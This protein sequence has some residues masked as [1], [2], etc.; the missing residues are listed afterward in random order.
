MSNFI[1]ECENTISEVQRLLSLEENKDWKIRYANY[2]TEIAG[3]ID[4]IKKSK[5]KKFHEWAPL[6]L[7][8]NVSAAKSHLKFSLR[9]LGQDVAKLKVNS[10]KIIISTKD[11]EKKNKRDFKCDVPLRDCE[12]RSIDARKFRNHFSSCLKRTS[13]SRKNNDE[14][15]IESL[16][17]TEF[18][19]KNSKDK[20]LCN[21]QPVKLAGISRFQMPTPLKAS[22]INNITH[23]GSYGGGIDILAQIGRGTATKLC[24]M[25]VKDEYTPKEPPAKVIQQG[26]AYATFIRELLRTDIG[27]LWWKIFGFGGDVPRK[28]ELY[29]A[30]VM[31]INNNMDISFTNSIISADN[32]SQDTF[33]L[34]YVYFHEEKNVLSS[35]DTSIEKCK[36][37]QIPLTL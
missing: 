30:C 18:S 10:D 1:K 3:N 24:V 13:E 31:P 33:H 27:K 2:A 26:L 14:H 28:L 20:I 19:K 15:R 17:L 8:M 12:W 9:Y 36:Q 4:T 21:I 34:H 6:Y 16:L 29:V 35:I 7:Y 37:K 23:S 22:N 11:F 5:E 25:E 32:N